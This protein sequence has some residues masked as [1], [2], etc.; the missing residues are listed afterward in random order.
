MSIYTDKKERI[1]KMDG[2]NNNDPK[3]VN[4]TNA[5]NSGNGTGSDV[6]Q[7]TNQFAGENAQQNN[8]STGGTGAGTFTQEQVN[9]M[10]T[11]EKKQGRAAAYRE[12][13]IDPND[14]NA[15]NMM[16]MFKAFMASMQTPEQQ[17][18]QQNAQQQIKIAE[19][20]SR[21]KKA[22][23]KAEAMQ[24]GVLPQFVDDAVI[25]IMSKLDDKTDVKTIVGELKSKYPTWFDADGSQDGSSTSGNGE[26][27]GQQDKTGQN[28]TGSSV[29]NAGKKGSQ[30]SGV[31][32]IGARLAAQRKS[33]SKKTSFW[34]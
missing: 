22:E 7:N 15:M 34:S 24:L 3:N 14:P 27:N 8:Q 16:N 17:A 11:A 33:S 4:G 6:Q 32:G 13:G 19:A 28:G 12:M 30:E 20:E 18:Q 21:A 29:G 31:S 1:I 23:A 25:I 9:R 5:D 26:Q 2:L 10:M